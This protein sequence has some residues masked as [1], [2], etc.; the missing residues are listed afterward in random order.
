MA[1]RHYPAATDTTTRP[2][3]QTLH[4]A[5]KRRQ[6]SEPNPN[7]PR[8]NPYQTRASSSREITDRLRSTKARIRFRIC[9]IEAARGKGCCSLSNFPRDR[10][11]KLVSYSISKRSAEYGLTEELELRELLETASSN[12]ADADHLDSMGELDSN[13]ETILIS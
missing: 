8:P 10:R 6:R 7:I 2:D 1:Q 4:Q 11:S 3:A 12:S 5:R 13:V 9:E